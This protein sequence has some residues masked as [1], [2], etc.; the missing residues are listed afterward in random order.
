MK[1]KTMTR[2]ESDNQVAI[3][4]G[5]IQGIAD[6]YKLDDDGIAEL[7]A[8]KNEISDCIFKKKE[9]LEVTDELK[10]VNK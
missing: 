4:I 10:S 3:I 1:K 9:K 2:L 7:I 5:V 8:K 6:N